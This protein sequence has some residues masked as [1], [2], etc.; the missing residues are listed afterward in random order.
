MAATGDIRTIKLA[1]INTTRYLPFY[2]E[3]LEYL[4]LDRATDDLE[5]VIKFDVGKHGKFIGVGKRK[6]E[7]EG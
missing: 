2:I 3:M 4:E 6:I 5:V 1:S 7:T